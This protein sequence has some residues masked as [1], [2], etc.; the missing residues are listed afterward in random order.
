MSN[1]EILKLLAEVEAYCSKATPGPWCWESVAEKANEFV[2]GI[3]CD[4]NGKFFE[5]CIN[6]KDYDEES[7]AWVEDAIIRRTE[8]GAN[9]DGQANFADAELLARA[10][11]DLPRL[12]ALLR[13]QIERDRWVPVS[14]RLPERGGE[15]L[16]WPGAF[17]DSH[18]AQFHALTKVWTQ[19]GINGTVTQYVTHW[20]PLPVPPEV[21][22]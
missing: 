18:S 5:G 14:E 17:V 3:A 12:V 20:R 19:S 1:D 13:E 4:K 6:G 16:V 15:Y 21:T 22:K 11:T 2:V 10:R 9:E 7:D 8:I